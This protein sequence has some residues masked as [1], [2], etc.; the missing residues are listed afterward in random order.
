MTAAVIHKS[1]NSMF[2]RQDPVIDDARRQPGWK[3]FH[4]ECGLHGLYFDDI[5]RTGKSKKYTAVTFRMDSNHR[6]VVAEGGG[7]GPIR[8]VAETFNESVKAG[9][10][11][12]PDIIKLLDI[13]PATGGLVESK[14]YIVG[15]ADISDILGGSIDPMDML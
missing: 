7:M 3:Q 2:W 14:P 10:A 9:F 8:A 4:R 12:D 5:E 1:K 13:E 11:I 6:I 15:T